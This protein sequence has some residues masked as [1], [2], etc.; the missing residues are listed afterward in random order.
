MGTANVTVTDGVV[1][2]WGIYSSEEARQ[3]TRVAAENIP[4]V[5]RVEDHRQRML[6]VPYG[7]I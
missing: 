3:A 6:N 4:G 2:F 7:G 5:R 1:E